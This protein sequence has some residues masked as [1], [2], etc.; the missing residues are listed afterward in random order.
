MAVLVRRKDSYTG[1][2]KTEG[3]T[4]SVLVSVRYKTTYI[5]VSIIEKA[6]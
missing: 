4:R 6:S 5:G 3:E 1:F 2:S